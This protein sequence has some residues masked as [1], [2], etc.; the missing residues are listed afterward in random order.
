MNMSAPTNVGTVFL[1]L[2]LKIFAPLPWLSKPMIIGCVTPHITV[3]NDVW[4]DD[5]NGQIKVGG[6]V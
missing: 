1:A 2:N 4:D 3:S 6:H 5:E